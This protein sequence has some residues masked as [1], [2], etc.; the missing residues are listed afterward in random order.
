MT[1]PVIVIGSGGHAKVVIEALRRSGTPI[2][3][4][5]DADLAKRHLDLAGV[6]YLG[7]DEALDEHDPNTVFLA[8]GIGSTGSPTTRIRVFE[9]LHDRGFQFARIVHPSAIIAGDADLGA[10]VQVMAGAIVQPGC[11]IG[12][13]AIVNTGARIDHDCDI[14]MHVHVAPG[15]VLCGEVTVGARSHVGAGSVI[16][17]TV[18]VGADCLVAAGTVVTTTVKNGA[19]IAGVPA[20]N[21]GR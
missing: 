4:R 1:R 20:R 18:T 3:G 14:G 13:N 7:R 21:I 19:R 17:Q 2:L 8:N 6:P 10:G 9:Q 11:R 5:T 16:I 12:A 15:A